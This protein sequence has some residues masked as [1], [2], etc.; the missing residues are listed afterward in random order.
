MLKIEDNSLD[1]LEVILFYISHFSLSKSYKLRVL[2]H[3]LMKN[4]IEF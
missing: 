2:T 4:E 3:I 1:V